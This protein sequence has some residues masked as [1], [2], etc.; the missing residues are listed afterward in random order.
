MTCTRYK[1]SLPN[2]YEPIKVDFD[3]RKLLDKYNIPYTEHDPR[4]TMIRNEILAIE[5]MPLGLLQEVED[6]LFGVKR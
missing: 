6:L 3:I 2:P 4:P 5:P 1:E